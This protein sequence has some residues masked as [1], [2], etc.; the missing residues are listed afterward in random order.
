M[1]L[2]NYAPAM[3]HGVTETVQALL[4]WISFSDATGIMGQE[5]L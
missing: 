5:D 1:C 2:G 3:I 4:H